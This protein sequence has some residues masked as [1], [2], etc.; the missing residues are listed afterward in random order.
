MFGTRS[1]W[2]AGLLTVL[3][4]LQGAA[5]IAA[6][7]TPEEIL[8]S[9]GLTKSSALYVLNAEADFLERFAQVQPHYFQLR[10]LYDKL[11]AIAQYQYQYDVIENQYT[12]VTEQLRNVQAE[13]DAFPPTSNNV[14]KEQWR[15]LLELE[16]QLRI[17]RNE[18]DR[19][20]NLR[21]K[22]LVPDWQKEKLTAEFRK[23]REDFL[24]ET[25]EPRAVA[26]KIKEQYAG[27]SKD[28]AVKKAL[29]ALRLSTKTRLDLGPTLEFKKKSTEL[30]NAERELS[31]AN[32]ARK[33][34]PKKANKAQIERKTKNAPKTKRAIPPDSGKPGAGPS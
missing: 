15:E 27:L 29:G 9:R 12:L 3:G 2:A 33:A 7:Q 26:D 28:E 10:E 17:Q 19:E 6:E 30:K 11:A 25:Q 5:A 20:L 32:F 4:A 24:K 23:R 1:S 13:Q 16:R 18:L 8:T 31:P 21:Y 14:L 34:A 22:N